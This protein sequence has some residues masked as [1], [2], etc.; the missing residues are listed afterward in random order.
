M[1]RGA[2]AEPASPAPPP[3]R[4]RSAGRRPQSRGAAG[5]LGGGARPGKMAPSALLRP[6]SRL[7]APAR[8]PS[9]CK[10]PSSSRPIQHPSLLLPGRTWPV[11]AG[12][13]CGPGSS[14]GDLR[15]PV[16]RC[17]RVPPPWLPAPHHPSPTL[18]QVPPDPSWS[19]RMDF[20]SL[21]YPLCRLGPADP[22]WGDPPRGAC[23]SPT[24]E[25]SEGPQEPGGQRQP[26]WLCR[27]PRTTSVI[28][29]NICSRGRGGGEGRVKGE[30][31][32]LIHVNARF[33]LQGDV[34][35]LQTLSPFSFSAVK[36][37]HSGA[38]T[39]QT[40]L[41]E[42]WTDVG[43]LH[44]LVDLCKS[45]LPYVVRPQHGGEEKYQC[46]TACCWAN[47]PC[48]RIVI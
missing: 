33:S 20:G 25:S 43:H 7:L 39:W 46:E 41:A 23:Y 2:A 29:P 45:L 24:L 42:S 19:L 38:A 48:N 17:P 44:L 12:S 26:A 32:A 18:R 3:A 15:R 9:G 47:L 40:W 27:W 14:C 6:F 8:L 5:L 28:S 13:G 16:S 22:G 10:C 21:L 34:I 35:D 4:G 36:I 1:S 11:A 37:L 30:L 31:N